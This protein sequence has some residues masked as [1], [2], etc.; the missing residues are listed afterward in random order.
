MTVNAWQP[1]APVSESAYI[2]FAVEHPQL[3]RLMFGGSVPLSCSPE[4]KQASN[5]AYLVLLSCAKAAVE[6][7]YAEWEAVQAEAETETESATT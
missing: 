7:L 2:E 5:N 4:L 3:F 1:Y 6:E